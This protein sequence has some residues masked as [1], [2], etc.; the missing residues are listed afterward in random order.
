METLALIAYRQPITR[1]DIEEVRGVAVSSHIIKTLS[2]REWVKV[3]GHRDVPGRP[4][5]YATT[6]IFLDY[7]N[8]SSLEELPTLGELKDIDGLN[9]KLDLEEGAAQ[10]TK[11]E[12]AES[13]EQENVD[14][15]GTESAVQNDNDPDELKS[16]DL[17]STDLEGADLGSEELKSPEI[18]E[19]RPDGVDQHDD[20]SVDRD[21]VEADVEE[22]D[23]SD[24]R[25]SDRIDDNGNDDNEEE[26]T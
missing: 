1:G 6:K 21:S 15:A 4:A 22:I 12:K 24:D 7:F 23:A 20:V 17:E 11:E 3:V 14:E 13:V 9:Q 19:S 25:S 26:R 8:L 18:N 5:L 2:E 10:E 16:T